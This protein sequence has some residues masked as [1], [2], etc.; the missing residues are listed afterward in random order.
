[1]GVRVSD[2]TIRRLERQELLNF[3]WEVGLLFE[4]PPEIYRRLQVLDHLQEIHEFMLTT[5][6]TNIGDPFAP[7]EWYVDAT[8]TFSTG[9]LLHGDLAN[10][11]TISYIVMA[12]G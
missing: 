8:N 3:H 7:D 2:Y 4:Y 1:M 12:L 6:G 10:E 11:E 9:I 5:F